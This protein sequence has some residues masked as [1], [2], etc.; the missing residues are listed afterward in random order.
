MTRRSKL[1]RPAGL[2]VACVIMLTGCISLL[3]ET[4]PNTL[5]RL[6]AADLS[7]AQP[8][9]GAQ[10]VIIGTIAAPRGLAGDRIA[11]DRGGAIAYM[12]GAAWLSPAP[13]MLYS[14]LVDG[15]YAQAPAISPARAEDGVTARYQLDLELIHFEASYDAGE[16]A[17]PLVNASLRARLIDRR[18]RTL[19][20]ARTL[21]ASQ[22]AS[23][24]RQGAIVAAFST[25]S[26][27]LAS[28][29]AV[30]TEGLVCEA[31]D[32]PEPCAR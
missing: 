4:Q 12:A 18:N 2:A 29:L 17:A 24:N 10:T 6:Q 31:E 3:P 9:Q 13:A 7:D 27:T 8:S 28:N 23:A 30:W 22:R 26:N 25:A 32:A 19:V 15:F 11:I 5:Y 14:N 20:S 1:L 16:D 21:Q